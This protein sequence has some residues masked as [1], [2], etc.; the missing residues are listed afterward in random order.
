[1]PIADIIKK[2]E[3]AMQKAV[4]HFQQEIG[5]VRTGRASTHLLDGIQVEY[6]GSPTALAQV[7]TLSVPDAR[8]I[9]IQPWEKSTLGEIEK[10][11]IKSDLGLN[12][13]NDG[14]VIRVPVPPLTEERRK[15]YVKMVKKIAEDSRVVVRNVR[16]EA[17][18]TLR[19]SEKEEHY[20]EDDRKRA[21]E[22]V[23]RLTNKY[24]S[25]IDKLLAQKE[26]EIMEV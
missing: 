17:N 13:N 7:A 4:E 1:M 15:E 12:P 8:S 19:K 21:E 10:A 11:I 25:E 9:L 20:S 18:D 23:Q 3:S 14:S 2:S 26:V 6:Y 16:R 5:K 22:D 24:V